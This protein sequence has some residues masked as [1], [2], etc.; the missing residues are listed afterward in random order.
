MRALLLYLLLAS[1]GAF[2]SDCAD[3]LRAAGTEHEMVKIAIDAVEASRGTQREKAALWEEYAEAI[4]VRVGH[5][6]SRKFR[7]KIVDGR[8]IVVFQ[9]TKRFGG[10]AYVLVIF[11]DG[12][13][14]MGKV[15]PLSDPPVVARSADESK[16]PYVFRSNLVELGAA[17]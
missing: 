12:S 13:I 9:G 11:P 15:R 1:A 5:P 10:R 17:Q 16:P 6:V 4:R 2:A 8:E 14:Y 7:V 3:R